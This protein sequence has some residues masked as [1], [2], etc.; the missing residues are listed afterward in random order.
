MTAPAQTPF[1]VAT[2]V[3]IGT[4]QVLMVSL[5]CAIVFYWA[6]WALVSSYK[7]YTKDEMTG[8]DLGGAALR[9]FFLLIILLWVFL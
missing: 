3:Q 1:E 9:I 4:V 8:S 7:G 2:G 6:M 5:A